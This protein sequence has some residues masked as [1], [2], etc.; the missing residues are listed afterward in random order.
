MK[1]LLRWAAV[2]LSSS[3]HSQERPKFDVASVKECKGVDRPPPST[4]SPGRLS[5]SCSPL[6]RLIWDAYE[7][8]AAGKIDPLNPFY[9]LTPVDGLP[10][11]VKSA[12]Y[13]I[14]AKSE[15]PQ[16]PAMMRGPMM[17]ALLEDRFQLQLHRETRDVPVYF[18]TVAKGGPRLVRS[19]EGGCLHLDPSD[20]TQIPPHPET[21][22]CVWTHRTKHGA[23]QGVEIF[24]ITLDIFAKLLHDDRPVVNRTGL[25]GA[26]DIVLNDPP[27]QPE[28]VPGE[29]ARPD[30]PK[31]SLQELLRTQ[32]G[33]QLEPGKA[34]RE[35]LVI[36]RIARPSAN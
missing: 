8:Y 29:E 34:P 1:Y 22:T 21:K 17:Q 15:S 24:G 2:I 7:I 35:F 20:L 25:D 31:M 9:P 23:I 27:D 5:L 33:L 18:L 16:L 14:D 19:K 3:L 4:N 30:P 6:Q 10:D 11:W 36:D 32:L 13:S 12:R 26:F 28:R